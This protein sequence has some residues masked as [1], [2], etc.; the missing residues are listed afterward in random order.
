[1]QLQEL[2]PDFAGACIFVNELT[3]VNTTHWVFAEGTHG[4]ATGFTA[5]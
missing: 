5:Q 4:A 2:W 1:M 3:A